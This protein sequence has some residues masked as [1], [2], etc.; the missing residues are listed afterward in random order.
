MNE[1]SLHSMTRRLTQPYRRGAETLTIPIRNDVD[2]W[3]NVASYEFREYKARYQ[4]EPA[5]PKYILFPKQD[6]SR[7][8]LAIEVEFSQEAQTNL[9][10]AID[11][12]TTT[13][14]VSAIADF[15]LKLPFTIRLDEEL[16]TV[17]AIDSPNLNLWTVIR[18]IIGTI[19]TAH[20]Q[21]TAVIQTCL[22]NI[23]P[24]T[25]AGTSF[26]LPSPFNTV[27]KVTRFRQLPFPLPGSGTQNWGIIALL[28][29]LAKLSWVI[30][31]EKDEIRRNL[32]IVQQQRYRQFASG[33]SLDT[34][35]QDLRVPR[36]PPREYSY[37]ENTIALYHFTEP[38]IRLTAAINDNITTLNVTS[39]YD[40]AAITPFSIEIDQEVMVVSAI[41]GNTWTVTRSVSAATS[42]Q[43]GAMITLVDIV[44]DETI[45]FNS[46]GHLGTHQGG[47]RGAIGKFGKSF[48]FSGSDVIEIPDATDFEIL[49]DRSFTVEAFVKVETS[50]ATVLTEEINATTTTIQVLSTFGFPK[51]P[52]FTIFIDDEAMEVTAIADNTWTVT[53]GVATAHIKGASV[54]QIRPS[55]IIAKGQQDTAGRLTGAGW[56]LLVGSFRGI[57]HNVQ[58]TISDG[59]NPLTLFADL[60][61]GDDQFHHV[62]GVLDRNQRRMRLFIDGEQRATTLIGGLSAIINSEPIRLGRSNNGNPFFGVIDEVRLSKIARTD[63]NPVLGESDIQYRQ[64]LGIF[65]R[66]Q[67][68]TPDALLDTINSLVSIEGQSD[69]FIL[70][71]KDPPSATASQL[72]RILPA[73][74][75]VGRSID[76]QGNFRT[77]EA[78][79]SGTPAEDLAFNERYLLRHDRT[80]VNYGTDANNHLM[81]AVTIRALDALVD[82]LATA[83]G[84]LVIDK[85]FDA[86]DTGLHR[87]GRALVMRHETLTLEALGVF[88]HQAGFDFVRHSGGKI[89]ASVA[90]GEKLEIITDPAN[91][92]FLVGATINLSIL[93]NNLPRSGQIQWRLIR[94]GGGEASF[95]AHPADPI[96]KIPIRAR[97]RLSLTAEADGEITVRVEYTL[98]RRT[99]TGTKTFRIGIP[100][101]AETGNIAII[102]SDGTPLEDELRV[103][104]PINLQ[105]RLSGLPPDQDYN[106]SLDNIGYGRGRF[107]AVLRPEVLFTPLEPGLLVLNVTYLISDNQSTPPYT[108]EIR[109]KPSLDLPTTI[110]AKEKYDLIM[111][112]LNYFHPSGV[113]VI[114]KNIREHVVEVKGDLLQAFPGYTYPDFRF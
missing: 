109:L 33:F 98:D 84:N 29:N 14:Q 44:I 80:Q 50:A 62:A 8:G 79:I 105:A 7:D 35:G 110:I 19:A 52:P 17:I 59:T 49:G 42:H 18:A 113:E 76:R 92:N 25:L 100:S 86:N 75:P 26:A 55:S 15:S 88:A 3:T 48:G 20:P 94:C 106:W 39:N 103:G 99:V 2:G 28:G 38:T 40:L 72:V 16:M 108:F 36:F 112:I 90:L 70:I 9:S 46:S 101:V 34:L 57:N 43:I 114:T 12:V 66:W 91:T 13:L 1:L 64:R 93:P 11:A 61:L 47:T 69:S 41:A 23:P 21:N 24:N 107:N 45:R 87:V 77:Q 78:E 60:N 68:P 67:L 71:E 27:S 56:S 65:E 81:Q 53:R 82:L 73:S 63:F 37:D 22:L 85:S 54:T 30:G 32:Q 10:V 97:P 31:W 95:E 83:T 6:I 51:N 104:T 102:R 58:W 74:L 89:Y 4:E 111:N 96:S 5:E